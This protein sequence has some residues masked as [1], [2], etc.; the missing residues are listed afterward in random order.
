MKSGKNVRYL[1]QLALLTAL[2]LVMANT[3]LGYI[4][5]GLLTMSLMTVPLAI[6]AMLCGPAA[7]A[8]LGFVFG[9]TSFFNAVNGTGGLTAYAFQYS[10]VLCFL[11]CVGARVLCGLLVGLLYRA[12]V[13]LLPGRDW[14]LIAAAA[15]GLTALYLLNTGL[16]AIVTYWGHTLGIAI[17]TE[18]RR[19]AFDH[20][21]RL[22]FS[23][24]DEQ[25]TGRLIA[26]VTKD[27]EDIGEVAHHGPEDLFIAVMTFLGAF[28]APRGE[29]ATR[30]PGNSGPNPTA[31]FAGVGGH[32][33]CQQT[34]R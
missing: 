7:G 30:R 31:H 8:W 25:K 32:L 28:A 19:R 2:M 17:E 10:P 11:M 16:M 15:A 6:G 29:A 4:R 20:L 26:R 3:F 24:Y 12:F 34:C 27:L 5:V 14:R 22:S 9:M 18:M 1:T 23:F 33:S 13:R 21:Q